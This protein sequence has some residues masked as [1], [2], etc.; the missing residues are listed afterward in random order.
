[1]RKL[2]IQFVLWYLRFWAKMALKLHHPTLIGIGGSVGKSSTKNAL[3]A[4][5]KDHFS[6]KFTSGNSE[7]GVPFG[8]LGLKMKGYKA[9]DWLKVLFLAPFGIFYLKNIRYLI[10]EMGTDDPYPP[11]NMEYLLTIVKPEIAL[12]LNTSPAHTFQFEKV[13]DKEEKKLPSEQKLDAVLRKMANEDGKIITTSG[14]DIGIYC[15]DNQYVQAEIQHYGKNSPKTKLLAFG[16]AKTNDLW[17]GQYRVSLEETFFEFFTKK[18]HLKLTFKGYALPLEYREV[19]GPAILT[20]LQLGLTA[21]K[22]QASLQKNFQIPKGRATLLQ[23]IHESIIIDSSYNASPQAV[24]A[25][26]NL[27]KTL[28]DQTKRPTVFLF[29]DM[30][31]LGDEAE[32]EHQRILAMMEGKVDYLFCTGS[33]MR[34]YMNDTKAGFQKHRWFKNSKEMGKELAGQLPPKALILVKGSQNEIFLEEAIKPLLL[35][36]ED[37]KNLCRQELFW[38]KNF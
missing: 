25:F 37:E 13:L 15:E 33:L 26:L 18:E 17:Y 4:I 14:C 29:G 16:E 20:A 34:Q 36:K 6:T 32:Y 27:L 22:I 38:V 3:Y 5:L 2:I 11:K 9:L 28:K 24:Q 12:F 10:V 35:Y 31:E 1:M 8:I 23:G 21:K 19:F 30:R 7:T